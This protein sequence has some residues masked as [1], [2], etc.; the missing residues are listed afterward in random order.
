MKWMTKPLA[1]GTLKQPVKRMNQA[2]PKKLRI[3]TPKIGSLFR[4]GI[5]SVRNGSFFVS[6]RTHCCR[7]FG[8]G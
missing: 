7:S 4:F 3:P 5:V 1:L 6:I 8:N 2:P